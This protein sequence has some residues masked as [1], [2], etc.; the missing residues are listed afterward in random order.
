MHGRFRKR[1]QIRPIHARLS[2][3]RPSTEQAE[4]SSVIGPARRC[5]TR[6]GLALWLRNSFSESAEVC[7]G[8]P[9]FGRERGGFGAVGRTRG[10]NEAGS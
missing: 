5:R 7:A 9:E 6:F 2:P 8:L 3:E 1:V 10:V 4:Y